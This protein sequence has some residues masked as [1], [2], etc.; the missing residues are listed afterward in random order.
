MKHQTLLVGA[1]RDFIRQI[2]KMLPIVRTPTTTIAK[3]T[4]LN[5]AW[6]RDVQSP[7][8]EELVNGHDSGERS[9]FQR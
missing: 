7:V 2:G 6:R 9:S 1:L 5:P 4:N 3:T 8:M